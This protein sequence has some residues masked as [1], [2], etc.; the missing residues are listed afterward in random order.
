MSF[1]CNIFQT[2]QRHEEANDM[3]YCNSDGA[4]TPGPALHADIL[5][6][7]DGKD[8]ARA[9]QRERHAQSIS[10]LSQPGAERDAPLSRE[11]RQRGGAQ[12]LHAGLCGGERPR[13]QHTA[14]ARVCRIGRRRYGLLGLRAEDLHHQARLHSQGYDRQAR[15]GLDVRS[16]Q[17]HAGDRA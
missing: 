7:A 10:G 5:H 12:S 8:E 17:V 9:V 13:R 16:H 4:L 2:R 3:D 15:E 6:R 11:G 1:L 14:L